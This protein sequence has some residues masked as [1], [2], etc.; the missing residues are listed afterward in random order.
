MVAGIVFQLVSMFIYTAVGVHFYLRARATLLHHATYSSNVN[1]SGPDVLNTKRV[2]V[3]VWTLSLAT[4]AIIVRG[5]YRTAELAQGWNGYAISHEAFTI[6]LDV[7]CLAL[8][9]IEQTP[10]SRASC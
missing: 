4:L 5:I 6:V 3:F 8:S 2:K 9:Q 10:T 7:S 1:T